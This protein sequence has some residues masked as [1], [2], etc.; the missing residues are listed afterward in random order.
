MDLELKIRTYRIDDETV[1]LLHNY[2]RMK[3]TTT[4]TTLRLLINEHCKHH[5]AT[6]KVE[7]EKWIFSKQHVPGIPPFDIVALIIALLFSLYSWL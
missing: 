5:E 3:K 1:G 6:P 7:G 2:A 4:S